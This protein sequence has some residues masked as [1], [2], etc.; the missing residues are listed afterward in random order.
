MADPVKQM[1]EL[2]MQE[3]KQLRLARFGGGGKGSMPGIQEAAT[4]IEALKLME[5]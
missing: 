5:E 4:S 3:R 1:G 2:S